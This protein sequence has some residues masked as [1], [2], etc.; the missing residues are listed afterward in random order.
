MSKELIIIKL[1]GS[2]ITDKERDTPTP[3][4]TVVKD[5]AKQI[6]TL[7]GSGKYRLILVHGAGSFG[8]P[9]AKKYQLHKG[10]I[11]P[12]QKLGF[13]LTDQ[14]TL[15]LNSII[16][17]HLLRYAIPAVSLPP[18]SFVIQSQGKLKQFDYFLIQFYIGQN[19]VPL[20]FGDVVVDDKWGCS[21]LSGD[22]IVAYLGQKLNADK[23][24][25]LSDVGGVYDA[26]P[27]TNPKARLIKQIND[28][29]LN[30]VLRGLTTS[31]RADVT[32]EM[33][34]KIDSI[35]RD[36]K[37]STI[38]IIN[39]LESDNLIRA[40]AGVAVGTKIYFR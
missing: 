39:G 20:L 9:L 34:G 32:G 19:Q 6:K 4:I 12:K 26:D 40:V 18:R 27:K 5:I 21:I 33:T 17:S 10:M 1:G 7:Y 31:A 8:H 24:V 29:N 16:L 13:A 35:K 38:W 2:V 36:L 25:F 30:Q 37:K 3:R 15:K 23:V 22:T 28:K 11:T 14:K